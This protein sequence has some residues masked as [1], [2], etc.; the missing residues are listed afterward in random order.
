MPAVEVADIKQL[1][2]ALAKY[3]PDLYKSMNTEIRGAL[4]DLQKKSRALVPETLGAGLRNFNDDGLTHKGRVKKRAFPRY[5]GAEVKKGIVIRIGATKRNSNGFVSYY[6]LINRSHAGQIVE[7]AGRTSGTGGSPKSKSNNP[8]AGA[9]FINVL[10]HEIGSVEKYGKSRQMSG[11]IIFRAA[12]EDKGKT[13]DAILHA[14]AKARTEFV[15]T[16][17]KA[18]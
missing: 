11:R 8:K 2:R 14:L 4:K 7:W 3:A 15:A 18:A 12:V 16:L 13:R 1:R 9:H 6:S 5:S 17:R 10:D